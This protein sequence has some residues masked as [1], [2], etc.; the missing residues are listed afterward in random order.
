MSA[1]LTNAEQT[2]A[3]APVGMVNIGNS[4]YLASILQ[5]LLATKPLVEFFISTN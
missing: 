1:P 5:A 4:C 3:F 2:R